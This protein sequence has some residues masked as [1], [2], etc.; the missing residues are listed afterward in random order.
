MS[1]LSLLALG[2]AMAN[3][4][5]SHEQQLK[6]AF[7]FNFM[8]F[9]EWP[10]DAFADETSPLVVVCIGDERFGT[11]LEQALS[12]KTIGA[13]HVV[14]RRYSTANQIEKGCHVVVFSNAD[15]AALRTVRQRLGDAPVLLVGEGAHF[16]H[17]GGIIRLFTEDNKLRFEIN[18]QAAERA[19]LKVAAKLL[20]LARI[21]EG[22]KQP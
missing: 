7:V 16:C 22:G 17:D 20:K 4:D 5:P 18:T 21:H 6:A 13:R 11:A 12:G 19:R 15:A 9:V 14:L 10:V 2:G 8:Q 3:D 1:L